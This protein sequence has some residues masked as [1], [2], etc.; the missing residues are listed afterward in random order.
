MPAHVSP[1]LGSFIHPFRC[2]SKLVLLIN[3]W[4]G[5]ND[6]SVDGTHAWSIEPPGRDS[7]FLKAAKYTAKAWARVAHDPSIPK[8][9]REA[10]GLSHPNTAGAQ[11]SLPEPAPWNEVCPT[12][13]PAQDHETAAT[14]IPLHVVTATKTSTRNQ[15]GSFRQPPS[16]QATSICTNKYPMSKRPKPACR[17]CK[18]EVDASRGAKPARQTLPLPEC[19]HIAPEMGRKCTVYCQDSFGLTMNLV[20][21]GD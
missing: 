13:V 15:A 9:E 16:A 19:A 14:A 5:R 21:G 10:R 11:P 20:R 1:P 12:T 6:L 17:P 7:R 18:R 4:C 2:A 3:R 8:R